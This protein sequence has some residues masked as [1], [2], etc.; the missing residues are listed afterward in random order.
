MWVDRH[1]S[2]YVLLGVRCMC[3][4]IQ[5]MNQLKEH[6]LHF[7]FLLTRLSLLQ[8]TN[9]LNTVH[10]CIQWQQLMI[11]V[12]S[13]L[14]MISSACTDQV[15]DQHWILRLFRFC[16]RTCTPRKEGGS[17]P[18]HYNDDC[19]M[20]EGQPFHPTKHNIFYFQCGFTETDL[21]KGF[22]LTVITVKKKKKVNGFLNQTYT[23][24]YHNI[25]LLST[26]QIPTLFSSDNLG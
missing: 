18:Q 23:V 5:S 17:S 21:P 22:L 8:N 12:T 10:W 13:K 9:L 4:G 24:L 3:W 15:Y 20:P 1:F 25:S 19:Y 16:A 11:D 6:T 14:M 7:S 2:T 26:T